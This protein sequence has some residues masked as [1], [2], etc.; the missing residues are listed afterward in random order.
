MTRRFNKALSGDEKW[1][2]PN[3]LSTESRGC[4]PPRGARIKA[5]RLRHSDTLN[6][7]AEACS[8]VNTHF[9]L[10]LFQRCQSDNSKE[11]LGR[12]A[13]NNFASKPL[14]G[15]GGPS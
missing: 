9:F 1:Q 2:E 10:P 13:S 6:Q 4:T 7:M 15:S 3:I 12:A 14:Q 5:P 8:V 11:S